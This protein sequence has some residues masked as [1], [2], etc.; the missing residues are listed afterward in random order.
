M[1]SGEE[2]R[3]VIWRTALRYGV[4]PDLVYAMAAVESNFD[5]RA[6]SSK[7]AQGL[8][9][10]MPDTAARFGATDL[11]DPVENVLAGVRYMRHLLD[12]FGGDA[13]LA[14]AAYNAGENV[15]LANRGIPP[16]QE[17]RSYVGKVMRLFGGASKSPYASPPRRPVAAGRAVESPIYS[18]TDDAG[19]VHYSDHP[20]AEPQRGTA[21]AAPGAPR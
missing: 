18:Y 5:P 7:G 16:Y 20:P 21:G 6:V 1:H 2:F 9:Q 13:R 17:T 8:M 3:E 15:V 12:M 11:F 19:V 10:L 4:H 14:L